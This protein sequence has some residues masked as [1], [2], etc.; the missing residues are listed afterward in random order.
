MMLV[1]CKREKQLEPRYRWRL[2]QALLWF[3]FSQSKK[4]H[5]ASCVVT[6]IAHDTWHLTYSSAGLSAILCGTQP[7]L[8]IPETS[9]YALGVP[10]PI[11][12]SYLVAVLVWCKMSFK[13]LSSCE[14]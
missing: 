5:Q 8:Y 11:R 1:T 13:A 12:T 14:H 10:I 6:Y 3:C 4:A 7:I 9:P 2:R